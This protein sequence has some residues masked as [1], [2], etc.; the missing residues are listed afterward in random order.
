MKRP[1]RRA[2]LM[3]WLLLAPATIIAGVLFWA[4]R[5]QTPYVDPP[6]GVEILPDEE[7]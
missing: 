6:T 5:P 3:M 2:H 4:M 1:H 7:R